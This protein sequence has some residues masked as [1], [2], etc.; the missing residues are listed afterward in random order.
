MAYA[1]ATNGARDDVLA[2]W[3]IA[4]NGFSAKKAS[5]VMSDVFDVSTSPSWLHTRVTSWR[6]IQRKFDQRG[7]FVGRD[8]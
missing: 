6:G 2:T 8:G 5:G 1:E 4:V 3:L 7:G